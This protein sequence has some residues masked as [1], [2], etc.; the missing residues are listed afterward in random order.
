[1]FFDSINTP[2]V[3]IASVSILWK[4]MGVRRPLTDWG[5]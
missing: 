2:G 1:M 4:E 5:Q 3:F